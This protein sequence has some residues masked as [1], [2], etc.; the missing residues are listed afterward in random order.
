MYV[1]EGD[2]SKSN[3]VKTQA[4]MRSGENFQ[5]SYKLVLPIVF[6][7]SFVPFWARHLKWWPNHGNRAQ[8]LGVPFKMVA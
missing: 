1:I 2:S 7:H 6:G 8:F 5:R 3:D 4:R